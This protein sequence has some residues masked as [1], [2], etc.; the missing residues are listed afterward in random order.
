MI[1][2]L[3]NLITFNFFIIILG[4]LGILLNRNCIIFMLVSAELIFCSIIFFFLIFS[5]LIQNFDGQII[6]LYILTVVAAESAIG[7]SILVRYYRLRD[8][9]SVDSM[10]YLKG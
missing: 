7:L 1:Y 10:I 9:I 5:Y 4:F 3:I 8:T 6:A 2:N